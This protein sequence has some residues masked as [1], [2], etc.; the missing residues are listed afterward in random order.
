MSHANEDNDGDDRGY[1]NAP[2]A[3]LERDGD[4][5]DVDYDQLW[6]C[7]IVISETIT[8]TLNFENVPY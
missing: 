6:E 5:D 3:R 2:M 4:D 1:D 8:L 7:T